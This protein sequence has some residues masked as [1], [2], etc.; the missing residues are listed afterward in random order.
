MKRASRDRPRLSTASKPKTLIWWEGLA[1]FS[2][3]S[4]DDDGDPRRAAPAEAG[5]D[6][7]RTVFD[8]EHAVDSTGHA[9]DYGARNASNYRTSDLGATLEAVDHAAWDAIASP[10]ADRYRHQADGRATEEKSV[11]HREGFPLLFERSLKRSKAGRSVAQPRKSPIST[12]SARAG[13]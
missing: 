13:A 11:F 8:A 1:S 5:G 2:G 12:N 4:D 6:V 3:D 9:S 10:R 7:L